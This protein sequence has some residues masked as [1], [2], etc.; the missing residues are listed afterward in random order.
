MTT[1]AD[2][3][4]KLVILMDAEVEFNVVNGFAPLETNG[5]TKI[6]NI[7]S[8]QTAHEFLSEHMNNHFYSFSLDF[9]AKRDNTDSAEDAI[10]AA[11]EAIRRVLRANV[12]TTA[13]STIQLE[14]ESE[15]Y[16]AI[17]SGV[18][19]RCERHSATAKVSD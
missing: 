10:D 9:L 16:F 11:A 19:Y 14:T 6:L 4:D 15:P 1:R 8:K 13:W 7:Y 5:A 18:P 3:R 12:Q 17:I 2:V